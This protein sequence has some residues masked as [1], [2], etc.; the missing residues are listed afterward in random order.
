MAGHISPS[1]ANLT[2]GHLDLAQDCDKA[3]RF[4]IPI[5]TASTAVYVHLGGSYVTPDPFPYGELIGVLRFVAPDPFLN[6]SRG[7]IVDW[8]DTVDFTS[9]DSVDAINRIRTTCNLELCWSLEWEGNPD[10][11][12]IGVSSS[13]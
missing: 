4:Y 11:A 8:I 2:L 1:L 7:A 13:G 9:T 3:V 10:L 12:G 5:E 6:L